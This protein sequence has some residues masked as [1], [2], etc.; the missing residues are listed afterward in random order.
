MLHAVAQLCLLCVVP[1]ID[2]SNKVASN[3]SYSVEFYLVFSRP[4]N[5]DIIISGILYIERFDITQISHPV[6]NKADIVLLFSFRNIRKIRL[7]LHFVSLL[8]F[9]DILSAAALLFFLRS[10]W[11]Q[12]RNLGQ[13]RRK[14]FRRPIPP[15]TQTFISFHFEL[16]KIEVLLTFCA[17]YPPPW[18]VGFYGKYSAMGRVF[19]VPTNP[20]DALS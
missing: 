9:F 6:N 20:L 11:H 1:T 10:V 13:G 2:C 16:F 12:R 4:L 3:P 5:R 14:L 17:L 7:E 19:R 15:K 18:R 8:S